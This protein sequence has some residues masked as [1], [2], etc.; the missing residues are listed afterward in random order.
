M[1]LSLTRRPRGGPL[2]RLAAA[3]AAALLLAVAGC[4]AL[5]GSDAEPEGA[6]SESGLET[7]SISVGVL[8]IV[9]TAALHRA[10]AAGYFE[11]EGLTVELVPIQGGAVAIPQLVAGD[12]DLT[13]SSWTS[14]ILGQQQGIAEFR[15]LNASYDAAPNSFQMV[16]RPDSPVR[17]PQDLPG[18]RVAVNTFGS[19]TELIARSAMQ[20]NGVDPNSVEFVELPF[21]EMTPALQ[22]G[23]I[24]AAVAL[25]PALTQAT[26][27]VGAVSLLDVASGPTANMPLA[28][29]ATTASFADANPN[30]IAAFQRAVARGQAD[31]ANRNLV[32]ETLPLYT[33]ITPE[34]AALL[35]LGSWPTTV[36]ATRLQ[37]VADLMLEFGQLQGPFDVAPLLQSVG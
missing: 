18:R 26:T 8:P 27:T 9:D 25:E 30:T 11:E 24:D 5:G 32:E 13:W 16:V 37:R 15:V 14:V 2:A 21:P 6:P 12:L 23:Q 20:A 22:N 31:M 1:S 17:T 33:R 34:T 35:N 7:P 3:G 28:G 4:S 36:D 10:Q 29:V 19:I